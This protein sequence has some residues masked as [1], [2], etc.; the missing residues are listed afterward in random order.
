MGVLIFERSSYYLAYGDEKPA[1]G[2]EG[3]DE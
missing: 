1:L 2:L 3:L